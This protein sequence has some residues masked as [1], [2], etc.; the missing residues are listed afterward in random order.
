MCEVLIAKCVRF[1]AAC[2][3]RWRAAADLCRKDIIAGILKRSNRQKNTSASRSSTNCQGWPPA[4]SEAD[5]FR[6]FMTSLG[7]GLISTQPNSD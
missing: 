7:R 5:K 1:H 6:S 3:Y 4:A 2:F